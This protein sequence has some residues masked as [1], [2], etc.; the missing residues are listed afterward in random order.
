MVHDGPK[1]TYSPNLDGLA[2]D[3]LCRML[4]ILPAACLSI[5]EPHD[6]FNLVALP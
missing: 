3:D 6:F 4:E 5:R 2:A 1:L